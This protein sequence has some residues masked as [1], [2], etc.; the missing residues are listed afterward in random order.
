MTSVQTNI[1]LLETSG[2]DFQAPQ[3]VTAL[4]ARGV[5]VNAI[6]PQTGRLVTHRDVNR[7]DCERAVRIFRE[8]LGTRKPQS[9]F[10]REP[11]TP[12]KT[13]TPRLYTDKFNSLPRCYASRLLAEDRF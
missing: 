2:F 3:V 12:S 5:L 6:G 8:V 7:A 4:A 10:R 9:N 11:I 1:V 13:K